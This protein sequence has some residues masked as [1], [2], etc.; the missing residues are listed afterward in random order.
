[1]V[2]RASFLRCTFSS[3]LV[4]TDVSSHLAFKNFLRFGPVEFFTP[5]K[6]CEFKHSKDGTKGSYRV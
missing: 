1:M 3:F 2:L 5:G 6:T 4:T